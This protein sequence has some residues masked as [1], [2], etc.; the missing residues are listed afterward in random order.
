MF[1]LWTGLECALLNHS[2]SKSVCSYFSGD[3]SRGSTQDQRIAPFVAIHALE[4]EKQELTRGGHGPVF[5]GLFP[6]QVR[7]SDIVFSS[8][9][10][11]RKGA[12]QM[13]LR[14]QI[15]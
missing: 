3:G 14:T 10:L 2:F 11:L 12:Q 6:N 13:V 7:Q 9:F 4:R 5:F 15:H 8:P 1:S